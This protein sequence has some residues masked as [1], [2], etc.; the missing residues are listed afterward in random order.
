MIRCTVWGGMAIAQAAYI[1]LS[2][3]DRLCKLLAFWLI[4]FKSL[5]G[6]EALWP[7]P[8]SASRS[9]MVRFHV[10]QFSWA[11]RAWELRKRLLHPFAL[12]LPVVAMVQLCPVACLL[13]VL[14]SDE[15][16]VTSG[17]A[18]T[19]SQ[20][21]GDTAAQ[22]AEITLAVRGQRAGVPAPSTCNLAC[23]NVGC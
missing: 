10:R 2:A 17:V 6:L 16:A 13:G 5:K 12:E 4:W 9:S 7:H 1:C 19:W 3:S 15:R 20:S 22:L 18:S 21:C 23:S 8:A 11:G 14:P